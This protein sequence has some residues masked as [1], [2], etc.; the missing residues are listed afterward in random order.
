MKESKMSVIFAILFILSL[1]NIDA[2]DNEC[3]EDSD[4]PVNHVCHP[5]KT[6]INPCQ[7]PDHNPCNHLQ[8][9]SLADTAPVRTIIC[10]CPDHLKREDCETP[11]EVSY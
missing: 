11:S 7:T 1:S 10:T 6:C 2:N 3:L 8:I 9:C 4:C 5:S